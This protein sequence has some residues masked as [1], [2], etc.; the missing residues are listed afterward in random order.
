MGAL[1]ATRVGVERGTVQITPSESSFHEVPGALGD[2]APLGV[3]PVATQTPEGPSEEGLITQHLLE[4]GNVP[5]LVDAVARE[6]PVEVVDESATGEGPKYSTGRLA[7]GRSTVSPQG[8]DVGGARKAGGPLSSEVVGRGDEFVR[9]ESEGGG[10]IEGGIGS[11]AQ[12]IE[13]AYFSPQRLFDPLNLII[14]HLSSIAPGFLDGPN[15]R[16]EPDETTPILGW[17]VGTGEKRTSVGASEDGHGPS[18]VTGQQLR[19]GHVE[20]VNV[21]PLFAVHFDSDDGLVQQRGDVGILKRFVGHDV[22]PVAG[23]VAHGNH[24]GTVPT[25]RFV[26][27]VLAPGPPM[28]RIVAVGVE[29]GREVGGVAEEGHGET[30]GDPSP[31]VVGRKGDAVTTLRWGVLG[32]GKIGHTFTRDLG[33]VAGQEVHAVGSRTLDSARAFAAEMNVARSYG[34]YEE[35]VSDPEVDVVYVGTPHPFH[36]DNALLALRAG[37][38]VL[39]EKAFTMTAAEAREI[40][41]EARER[42]LFVMEAMWSRF[43]PHMVAL[44][45]LIAEGRLGEIRTVEADH[46]KWFAEDPSSRLYAPELGGSAILDL[47]VYPLSFA[48]MVLGLPQRRVALTD[49]A[50]T[51]VDGQASAILGYETGAHAVVTCTSSAR[52]AT[53]ACVAGTRARVEID[54]DFYAPGGFTLIDRGGETTRFEYEVEGRGL[55]YQALEVARCLESGLLESPVM[56]LDETIAIMELMEWWMRPA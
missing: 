5:V 27:R 20:G 51:G 48:V 23:G 35:L 33:L 34:S 28:N 49:A 4:V 37:K 15:Q 14:D 44:R 26:E 21:G 17:V 56:P 24:D 3:T 52:S 40:V 42:G 41:G 7:G 1:D 12:V 54:G 6:P 10:E 29:V 53:R 31:K 39:V 43:L 30:L 19:G 36:R 32:T 25:A 13:N 18:T 11:G 50:F 47:G 55:H 46:G 45:D 8:L 2:V 16:G 38:P 22:T 9:D